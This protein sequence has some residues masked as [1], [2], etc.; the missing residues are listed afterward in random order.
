MWWNCLRNQIK[1]V[2]SMNQMEYSI[3]GVLL[4]LV[5]LALALALLWVVDQRLMRRMFSLRLHVPS[6][7]SWL[8][9]VTVVS[10]LIGSSAMAACLSLFFTSAL[11][12]PLWGAMAL[13][14][15]IST[16]K[17]VETYLLSLK[18]TE[19]HRRY[20]QASGATHL[21]SVV[22]CARRALRAATLPLLW[23]RRSSMV[24]AMP[25]MCLVMLVFGTTIATALLSTLLTWAVAVAA[26]L[27]TCVLALWLADY[28]LFDKRGNLIVP[29][30][31]P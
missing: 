22:P 13:F 31:K 4:V 8:W 10:I 5:I 30:K 3:W 21:E 2:I 29:S 14:L 6:L 17:A 9:L 12:W 7:T 16:P 11:F 28:K 1:N 19:S 25:L 27:L 20:L 26:A 18:R 15:L 24:V 23:H